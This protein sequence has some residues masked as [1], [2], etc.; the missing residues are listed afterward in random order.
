MIL[1][2]NLVVKV[3]YQNKSLHTLWLGYLKNEMK[4]QIIVSI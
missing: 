1:D 4:I 3:I 2:G